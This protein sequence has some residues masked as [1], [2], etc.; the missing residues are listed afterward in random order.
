MA[1]TGAAD[2]AN[3]HQKT[4][5]DTP[6]QRRIHVAERAKSRARTSIPTPISMRFRDGFRAADASDSSQ[7]TALFEFLRLRKIHHA[8]QIGMAKTATTNS[9]VTVQLTIS[10][11][12]LA[13]CAVAAVVPDGMSN[14]TV[15]V[16]VTGMKNTM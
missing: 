3:P 4:A 11:M 7:S 1:A 16:V 8:S 6:I 10:T 2:S 9:V 15:V 5:A 14:L 12:S 13:C